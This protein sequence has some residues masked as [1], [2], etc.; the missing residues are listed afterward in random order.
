MDAEILYD[1][2]KLLGSKETLQKQGRPE[3]RKDEAVIFSTKINGMEVDG[4]GTIK[5]VYAYG[6]KVM[7]REVTYDIYGGKSG[8]AGTK[9]LFENIAESQLMSAVL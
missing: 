8:G 5:Q 1:A 6:T 4:Y 9:E 2:I 3:Y 7:N